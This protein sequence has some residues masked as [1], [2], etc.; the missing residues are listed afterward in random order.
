[1]VSVFVVPGCNT[2]LIVN[3]EI[4]GSFRRGEEVSSDIDVVVWHPCVLILRP[5]LC[6][7]LT[8]RSF[9]RRD[10]NE[11]TTRSVSSTSIMG[12]VLLALSKADLLDPDKMFAEGM[13]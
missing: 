1:M 6:G 5:W 13:S 12:Q 8:I 9:V 11:K 10:K 4:M 3:F 7:R 2:D